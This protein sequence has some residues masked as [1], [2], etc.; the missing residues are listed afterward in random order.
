MFDLEQK[1]AS[2]GAGAT[3]VSQSDLLCAL[4]VSSAKV[5]YTM[6]TN[7]VY[8]SAIVHYCS[9]EALFDSERH[10]LSPVISSPPVQ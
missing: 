8:F 6:T 5:T 7:F 10:F 3:R 2:V 1:L 4:L 9:T